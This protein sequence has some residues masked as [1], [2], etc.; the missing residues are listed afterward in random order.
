MIVNMLL[1]MGFV[2]GFGFVVYLVLKSGV[3]GFMK[4]VVFDYVSCGIC[5]NVVCFGGIVN[6]VIID[7][8]DNCVDMVWLM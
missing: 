2:S 1:I 3:V 4:V 7:W 5:V 8:L 6:M